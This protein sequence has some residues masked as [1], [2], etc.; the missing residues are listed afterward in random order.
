MKHKTAQ[1]FYAAFHAF[2]AEVRDGRTFSCEED[3][4]ERMNQLEA[5]ASALGLP[6]VLDHERY[7]NAWRAVEEDGEE[8]SSSEYSEE[9]SSSYYEDEDE[10]DE[11]SDD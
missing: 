8:D 9:E 1:D 11:S 7:L 4:V 6:F 10:E 5:S 2:S 3:V